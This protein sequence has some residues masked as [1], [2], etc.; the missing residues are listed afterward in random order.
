MEE[1]G[2]DGHHLANSVTFVTPAPVSEYM[3]PVPLVTAPAIDYVAPKPAEPHVIPAPVIGHM[4]P[5]LVVT[6]AGTSVLPIQHQIVQVMMYSYD[7]VL[8]FD[9]PQIVEEIAEMVQGDTL[10]H[11][12]EEFVEAVHVNIP[13][14]HIVG[15]NVEVIGVS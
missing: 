12:V 3:A 10:C 5:T 13:F 7:S 2:L 4:A 6:S 9:A 14:P 8:E 1:A 11:P 15:G